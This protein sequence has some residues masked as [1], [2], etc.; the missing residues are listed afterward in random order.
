[1][2]DQL[3]HLRELG[4]NVNKVRGASQWV[5]KNVVD[6][7][8]RVWNIGELEYREAEIIETLVTVEVMKLVGILNVRGG[9]F[10]LTDSDSV[11]KT[12]KS[13][14]INNRF[15]LDNVKQ[16]ELDFLNVSSN[17]EAIKIVRHIEEYL[18][19]SGIFAYSLGNDLEVI[20]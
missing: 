5:K 1:M 2:L 17:V 16:L 15:M 8:V 10:T 9:F 4:S 20:V 19:S 12:V 13:H 3:L 11:L 18:E 14:F 7:L 6:S